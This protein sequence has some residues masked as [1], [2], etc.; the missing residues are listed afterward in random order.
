LRKTEDS[1]R[2]AREMFTL[3]VKEKLSTRPSEYEFLGSFVLNRRK[4]T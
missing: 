3:P 1:N 2:L 4:L